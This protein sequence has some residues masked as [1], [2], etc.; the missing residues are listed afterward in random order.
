MSDFTK[1]ELSLLIYHI[2]LTLDQIS[3]DL[4]VKIQS[5][6][7][8]Y[9]EHKELYGL[10]SERDAWLKKFSTTN[11]IPYLLQEYK[12]HRNSE[13]WRSTRVVEELCEYCLHLETYVK[14]LVISAEPRYS[15]GL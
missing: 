5:I 2:G 9:C 10:V 12:K 6:I 7:D 15:G 4:A 13:L 8:N 3:L 1:D 11:E 14:G